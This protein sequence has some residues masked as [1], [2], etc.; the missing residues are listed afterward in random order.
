VKCNRCKTL[1]F[2]RFEGRVW[3]IS[4]RRRVP[5]QRP[6]FLQASIGEPMVFDS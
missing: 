4:P 6:E 1:D 2:E 3:A 5:T